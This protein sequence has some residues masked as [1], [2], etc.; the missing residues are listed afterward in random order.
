M[1]TIQHPIT[2][3]RPPRIQPKL[4]FDEITIPDPPDKNVQ[5]WIR[6]IQAGLPIIMIFGYIMIAAFGGRARS[7]I[8]MIPMAMSVFASVAFSIYMY[9]QEKRQRALMEQKYRS[10]LATLHED[11]NRYHEQQRRFYVHNYPDNAAI[12]DIST[13]TVEEASRSKSTLRSDARL[14]ER[15]VGDEDFGFIR[16]GTGMLPSTVQYVAGDLDPLNDDPLVRAAHKL[17]TDSQFVDEIPV[18]I[19]IR[20]Q[21]EDTVDD[22]E[23]PTIGAFTP[24]THALGVAG[25]AE[26]ADPLMQSMLLQF[27]AMHAPTDAKMY[28][29]SERRSAWSMLLDLPH[30]YTTPTDPNYHFIQRSNSTGTDEPIE[31]SHEDFLDDIRRALVQR[32]LQLENQEREESSQGGAEANFTFFLVIIDL[33]EAWKSE[34]SPLQTIESDAAIS[35]IMDEGARLGASVIFVASDRSKIPSKCQAVVETSKNLPPTN[36]KAQ[37]SRY[38]RYAETGVNTTRYV[39]LTDAGMEAGRQQAVAKQLA[40]CQIRQSFGAEIPS[41]VPL[42]DLMG[43]GSLPEIQTELPELWHG[44]T[45]ETNADWLEVALGRTAGSKIRKLRLSASQDGVH[46]MIAGSTGSGKSELLISLIAGLAVQYDPSMLNFVLV[47][48]KGGGAF[49]PYRDLPHCVDVVT[50]LDDDGVTRMFTAIQSEL[51]RRQALNTSTNTKD[52]VEY[53]EK[54]Y[55]QVGADGSAG[56]TYPFLLIIIDEFAEMIAERPEFR[57]E[58]ESIARVGRA[59]GVSL[60]LAA[61]RPTGVTDQMRSNM[62]FRICLRVETPAE[63]RE[64]LRRSDAAFLPSGLPGRGYLQ[65]GN[66]EPELIQVAYAGEPYVDPAPVRWPDRRRD[67]QLY[68]AREMTELYRI[69]IELIA[70]MA[71]RLNRPDQHAPWPDPLPTQLSLQDILIAEDENLVDENDKQNIITSSIYLAQEDRITLGQ[72]WNAVL[73]LSPSLTAWMNSEYGWIDHPDWFQYAIRPVVGLIDD[74]YAAKQIPMVIDLPRGHAV[75]FGASGWGKTTFF[76]TLVIS[77]TANHPPSHLHVY[78]LDLGGRNLSKLAELPHVGVVITPDEEG[79]VEKV[80]LLFQELEETIAQRTMLLSTEGI[81]SIYDYNSLHPESPE[82]IIVVGID[83]FVEFQETFKT[84]PDEESTFTR[85]VELAR[86]AK[87]YGIH[88][89]ISATDVSALSSHVLGLFSE[90]LTLKLTD[91]AEYRS[92]IGGRVGDLPDVPGRGYVKQAHQAVTF[93][94]ATAFDTKGEAA[95]SEAQTL[96]EFVDAINQY[97]DDNQISYRHPRS[98]EA[99]PQGLLYRRLIAKQ[100]GLPTDESF[101][102]QW[103]DSASHAWQDSLKRENADWPILSLGISTGDRVRRLALEAKKDG[104]HGM[105]AG[106]TGSGKSELLMT[107]IV[108]LALN[109]SP[110]IVNFVLVDY[111]GGGA[112]APF[113]ELPHCVDI[114]TNLNT[115]D[116]QRM[117]MAIGA[118]MQRRQALNDVHANQRHC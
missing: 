4:P 64:L 72:P 79:Y 27:A 5:G 37:P 98:I 117:F 47:D 116:V 88:I 103:R 114:I 107:M 95:R 51:Q 61:Q 50:N 57:A 38:F 6:L 110:E 85:F 21:P 22:K 31:N 80:T 84:G 102:G 42:L 105:I 76:R 68:S 32:K 49:E 96:G 26:D 71:A 67:E 55:H 108:E 65:I 24:A 63:S 35:I 30:L 23:I 94:V 16:L 2:I 7:P 40:M 106:G 99:L 93:Q 8:F 78:L 104:V 20:P 75:I 83:N 113:T 66:G 56:K 48:F 92:V 82:P 97:I 59:Q 43:Y 112:F 60:I 86:Q 54:G 74:P 14:W 46:G 115:A 19:S 73:T 45:I 15:R 33:M 100:W 34:G 52:I 11:M 90:R 3:D 13:A 18:V 62:K 111:K 10:H 101:F 109:Y 9:F 77:L 89:V 53:H 29:L 118:E 87:P 1:S 17:Q 36:R 12:V 81:P 41:Y 58:L 69:L 39:G 91:S 44:S 28:L 70:N 25:K